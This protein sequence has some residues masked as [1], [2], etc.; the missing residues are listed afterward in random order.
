[1]SNTIR[2]LNSDDIS[3]PLDNTFKN[4][5]ESEDDEDQSIMLNNP[6]SVIDALIHSSDQDEEQPSDN[7]LD[8]WDLT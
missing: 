3:T 1:M 4:K 2:S 5:S 7:G 6:S 8:H